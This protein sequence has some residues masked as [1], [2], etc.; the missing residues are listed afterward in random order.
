[1]N[2]APPYKGNKKLVPAAKALRKNMTPQ[3]KKL[4]YQYLSKYPVRFY[5]Q[6]ILGK[7]IADF[8]CAKAK[9]VVELD[10]SQHFKPEEKARDE[11]RTR[12]LEEYGLSVV[13]ISNYEIDTNIEGV[14][15][16]IDSTVKKKTR[17]MSNER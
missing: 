4:W 10:G 9:L 6:K 16:F 13:R 2:E 5:R 15:R 12:F 8:Y 7:Y 1:M 3:E 14:C 17:S 11:E